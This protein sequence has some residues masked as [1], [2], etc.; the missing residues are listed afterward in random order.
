MLSV[1]CT[2]FKG[3]K[4]LLT[5]LRLHCQ[6]HGIPQEI[7][8]DGSTIFCLHETQDFLRRFHITHRVSS[9]ANT[10]SNFCNELA[11][12]HLKWILGD[13]VGGSGNWDLDVVTQALLSHA[14]NPCKVLKKSPA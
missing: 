4:K 10:H 1:H 3:S 9:V 2:A 12:K 13:F 14:N 5:I 7:C 8:T 11:L 6:K